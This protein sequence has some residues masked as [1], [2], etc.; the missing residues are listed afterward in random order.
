MNFE[1]IAVLIL[2]GSL[3]GVG[4]IVFRK[5]PILVTLPK[6]SKKSSAG[7]LFLKF[8]KTIQNISFLRSFSFEV[9]LQKILSKIRILTL[10]IENKTGNWLQLLRER[11][12]KRKNQENDD[13]WKKLKKIAN[14][15][16]KR[17]KR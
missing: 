1:T 8:K 11:T 6:T 16:T 17:P 10:R 14:Q 13:Y 2:F 5:I 15:K 7:S 9:F 3:L 12:Q 4:I